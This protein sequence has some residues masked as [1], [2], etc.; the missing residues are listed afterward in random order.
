[1]PPLS[2]LLRCGATYG[3][4]SLVP[5]PHG[6]VLRAMVWTLQETRPRVRE[7]GG[8]SCQGQPEGREGA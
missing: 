3:A 7:G 4:M 2:L 5:H 8:D 1:M 6:G